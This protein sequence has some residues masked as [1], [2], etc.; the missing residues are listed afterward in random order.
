MKKA[1]IVTLVMVLLLGTAAASSAYMV[2]TQAYWSFDEGDGTTAY[3]GVGGNDGAISGAVYTSD[4]APTS[5]ND[6][7]LVFDGVDDFVQI[8]NDPAL[9]PSEIT[10]SAWVKGTNPGGTIYI[11]AKGSYECRAASY[12]FYT[13]M[14]NGLRFYIR[15]TSYVLSPNA[16][17]VWNGEWRHIVG[18]YDGA[19]VRLYVDGQEI[20][21]GTWTDLGIGYN[22]PTS[23]D[24]FVGTY[25]GTC[26]FTTYFP[27]QID[28]VQIWNRALSADEVMAL[29]INGITVDIDIKPGSDPNCVNSNNHGVIPVAILSNADFDA[30]TVDPFSVALDGA[31]VRVKGKSG[32][33]GSLEDVNGDGLLDLVVQIIDDAVY[34]PGDTMATLTGTTYDG[35]PIEGT[36]SICIVP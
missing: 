2:G 19:F 27:G 11:L 25:M 7:A 29:Y 24:L 16:V 6:S 9:E 30:A 36:D 10:V 15:N 21:D 4:A 13:W 31:E 28:E 26:T 35:V 22:L 17:G 33:L 8:P 34:E 32:N 3:D 14:N 1:L 12:A 20:E 5:G 23:N 18:T